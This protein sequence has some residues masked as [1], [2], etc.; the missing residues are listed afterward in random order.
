MDSSSLRKSVRISVILLVTVTSSDNHYY[1][2]SGVFRII[3]AI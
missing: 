1:L 3:E 2:I